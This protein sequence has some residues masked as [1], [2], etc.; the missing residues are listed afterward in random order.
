MSKN[1]SDLKTYINYIDKNI[2]TPNQNPTLGIIL[3]RKDNEFV[4]EYVPNDNVIDRE[5]E[6]I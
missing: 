3:C 4:F 6:L 1:R 5:Y 2:K